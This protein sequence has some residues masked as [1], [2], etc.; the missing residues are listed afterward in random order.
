[1]RTRM[2]E[3]LDQTPENILSG[4]RKRQYDAAVRGQEKEK[5]D[6]EAALE[7]VKFQMNQFPEWQRPPAV[8]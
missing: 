3:V 6:R 1:M 2:C 7:K 4:N 8:Q 5:R